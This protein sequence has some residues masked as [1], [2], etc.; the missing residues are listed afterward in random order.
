MAFAFA[1]TS[2]LLSISEL[3]KKQVQTARFLRRTFGVSE[4]PTGV[5]F[6]QLVQLFT[7][8]L[9]PDNMRL[10]KRWWSRSRLWR[11]VLLQDRA[12][13]WDASPDLAVALVAQKIR[14]EN[15][16]RV[17]RGVAMFKKEVAES[18]EPGPGSPDAAASERG[19][20][21]KRTHQQRT[22]SVRGGE[23]CPRGSLL[24]ASHCRQ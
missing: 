8:M 1:Y 2:R 13:F 24:Q 10:Q 17:Q 9:G 6:N 5:S 11:F 12:G 19:S 15:I 23:E 16:V 14:P 7:V 20:P 21:Q 22:A 18:W 3:A 4:T